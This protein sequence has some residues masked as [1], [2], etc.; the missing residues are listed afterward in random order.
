[1]AGGSKRRAD[2]DLLRRLALAADV[3]A[4]SRWPRGSA[5]ILASASNEPLSN[6]GAP[7]CRLLAVRQRLRRP[8]LRGYG[9]G[10]R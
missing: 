3:V 1:M 9:R 5:R 10:C 4:L 7:R 8:R 6:A 2:E